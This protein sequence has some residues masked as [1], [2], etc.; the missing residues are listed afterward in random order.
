MTKTTLAAALLAASVLPAYAQDPAP[1]APVQQ[2]APAAADDEA[3]IASPATAEDFAARAAESNN[4]EIL[5][6]QAVLNKVGPE[7]REF[8]EML[9]ADHTA[10]GERMRATVTEAGMTAIAEGQVSA[11]QEQL[12]SQLQG[13]HPSNT[14]NAYLQMQVEAHTR[15]VALFKS[16]A[17]NGEDGPLKTFA[18][19]TLPTLEAHLAKAEELQGSLDD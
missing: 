2:Q 3:E 8:A 9:I 18:T 1:A 5:S 11:E 15:A 6:S 4:F 7:V 17:E 10:A 16:Y 12:L 13:E 14:N 19:E